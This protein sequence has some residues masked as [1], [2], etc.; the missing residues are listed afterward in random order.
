MCYVFD[1]IWLHFIKVNNS[2][3]KCDLFNI[4]IH[5]TPYMSQ[6]AVVIIRG[7]K[8]LWGNALHMC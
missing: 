7:S 8:T 4:E 1:R 3:V 6:P 5:K 2:S